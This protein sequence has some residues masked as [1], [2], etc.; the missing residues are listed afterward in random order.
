MAQFLLPYNDRTWSLSRR[1]YSFDLR[2]PHY[3]YM[4]RSAYSPTDWAQLRLPAICALRKKGQDYLY[5]G[6]FLG[7]M[8][9]DG[10]LPSTVESALKSLKPYPQA[11]SRFDPEEVLR[12]HLTGW[13]FRADVTYAVDSHKV[14]TLYEI[15]VPTLS[16]ILEELE[17]VG[18]AVRKRAPRPT[19]LPGWTD[20][21]LVGS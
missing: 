9:L 1:P 8:S 18:E 7:N 16:R 19:V 10:S 13:D 12:E 4:D 17:G 15:E 20:W 3:S 2:D 5:W 14:N 11:D 6:Y 21:Y